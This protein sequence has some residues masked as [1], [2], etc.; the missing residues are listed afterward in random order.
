MQNCLGF[1][2][3]TT[4]Y[5]FMHL[6]ITNQKQNKTK[7]SEGAETRKLVLYHLSQLMCSFLYSVLPCHLIDTHIQRKILDHWLKF[8]PPKEFHFWPAYESNKAELYSQATKVF[9]SVEKPPALRQSKSP[10]VADILA[11]YNINNT[12]AHRIAPRW[13][14]A[15][16]SPAAPEF[17]QKTFAFCIHTVLELSG[18]LSVLYNWCVCEMWT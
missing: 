16:W 5:I 1:H 17:P 18:F 14:G 13:R 11:D 7:T 15:H 3:F 12:V 2:T 9:L 4:N 10:L 6:Y 8:W